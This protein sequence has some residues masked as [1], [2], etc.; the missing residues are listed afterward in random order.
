MFLD[1][2]KYLNE[3]FINN[4][5]FI[6]NK[7]QENIVDLQIENIKYYVRERELHIKTKSNTI[8]IFNINSNIKE[9]IEKATIFNKEK[10][11]INKSNIIYI[12]LRIKN[13]VFY[14]TT[15]T[16]YQ[17]YENLKNVYSIE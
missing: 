15:E 8:L 17:C 3:T 9:Q 1:Y 4:I 16:E 5:S 2:K 6:I 10:Q 11:N 7:V 12:D 13:K 14:C